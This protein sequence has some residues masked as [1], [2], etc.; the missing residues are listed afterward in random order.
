[1][2]TAMTFGSTQRISAGEASSTTDNGPNWGWTSPSPLQRSDNRG[3]TLG[4]EDA[5]IE[6]VCFGS[7][8]DVATPFRLKM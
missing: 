7:C 4:T 2:K 8:T 6:V 1:M 3:Y 5:I